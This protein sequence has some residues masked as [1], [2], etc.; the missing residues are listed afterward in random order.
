MLPIVSGFVRTSTPAS[1]LGK[2]LSPRYDGSL[3]I[4]FLAHVSLGA[5]ALNK[6]Q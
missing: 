5:V 3:S 4:F 1:S 2:L 6:H